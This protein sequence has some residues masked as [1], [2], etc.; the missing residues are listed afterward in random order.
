MAELDDMTMQQR[1]GGRYVATHYG[2][3][4]AQCRNV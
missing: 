3:V 4:I 2:E 1:Y